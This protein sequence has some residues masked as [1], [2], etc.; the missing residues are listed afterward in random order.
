MITNIPKTIYLQTGTEDADFNDLHEVSWSK[1]KIN[2]SDIEYWLSPS[3][4]LP[5]AHNAMQ[6][7]QQWY[8]KTDG[9]ATHTEINDKIGE[10]LS[11]QP[12]PESIQARA[13][14]YSSKWN[15]PNISGAIGDG[16]WIDVKD[17]LP[18][19]F[20]SVIVAA[21]IA[22][23]IVTCS[24]TAYYDNEKKKWFDH[25]NDLQLVDGI[26]KY[27]RERPQPPKH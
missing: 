25:S 10:L 16:G 21:K 26:I 12:T 7:F 18:Q 4:P 22:S 6:K 17:R 1:D 27:W 20:R 5:D 3:T 24:D 8:E 23:K 19:D 11:E 2:Q 9:I 14:E 15:D 13:E